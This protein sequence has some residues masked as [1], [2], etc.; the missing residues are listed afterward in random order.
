MRHDTEGLGQNKNL[1][2]WS[3][4]GLYHSWGTVLF[5]AQEKAWDF[6]ADPV[7]YQKLEIQKGPE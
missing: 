4:D 6:I 2:W 3:V 1:N 5:G 7:R